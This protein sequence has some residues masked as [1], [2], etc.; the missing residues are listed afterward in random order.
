MATV[1]LV[2]LVILAG[3]VVR[4]T[5]SGMGCPDWPR[6]FGQWVPPTDSSQLPSNYLD[7]YLQK[8]LQKNERM[9]RY[10]EAFGASDLAFRLRNDEEIRKENPFNVVQ[11]W[12][13]YINRLLGVAVG[14]A[15]IATV[16]SSLYWWKADKGLFYWSAASLLV[17]IFQGWIG[18]IVV[19]T[20]LLPGIITIHMVLALAVVA[21]LIYV[22]ARSY[23][24]AVPEVSMQGLG[25]INVVLTAS[26]I[27]YL[28]QIALGTQV[29]EAIDV[30]AHQI[31]QRELW[32]EQLGTSFFIHRSY[33]LLLL[34]LHLY[35]WW[36]VRNAGNDTLKS[37]SFWLLSSIVLEIGTGA[38][39][40][41]FSIPSYM[42]PIHL[43]LANL[44]FGLQIA[45]LIRLN[46]SR[47]FPTSHVYNTSNS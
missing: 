36:L 10:L 33:S 42:Q 13:E 28:G 19:S 46:F 27:L 31:Q 9:A 29:R 47:L 40:A 22:V 26:I 8:R 44:I 12:I 39:M 38:F 41:Y 25:R 35:I 32:I 18:S 34:G 21:M 23:R 3:G 16:I 14:L 30:I 43:L 2:Y 11:T 1:A 7:I 20:N 45:L 24:G 4:T 5:G 15:L 37:W 6:C 17:V